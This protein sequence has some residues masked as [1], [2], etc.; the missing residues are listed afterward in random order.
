MLR[1]ELVHIPCSASVSAWQP[2][3]WQLKAFWA[4]MCAGC[5]AVFSDCVAL[6]AFL[7]GGN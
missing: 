6:L 4:A 3:S 2:G 1:C 5:W 7:L